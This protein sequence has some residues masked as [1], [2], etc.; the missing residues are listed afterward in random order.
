MTAF[1]R[2][3]CCG[4]LFMEFAHENAKVTIGHI[5]GFR[6]GK[7]PERT[8]LARKAFDAVAEDFEAILTAL[9]SKEDINV[10]KTELS[11]QL[12]KVDSRL[13]P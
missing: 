10:L 2:A 5:P 8:G 4:P 3:A 1:N 9:A 13:S 7:R 11:A 6:G 12:A